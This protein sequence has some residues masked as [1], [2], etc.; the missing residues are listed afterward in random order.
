M[1]MEPSG[2]T[3]RKPYFL[4]L[5]LLMSI[6]LSCTPGPT[7]STTPEPDATSP[8]PTKQGTAPA[9]KES[10]NSSTGDSQSKRAKLVEAP[11]PLKPRGKPQVGKRTEPASNASPKTIAKT[12]ALAESF[13]RAVVQGDATTVE[14]LFVS[15]DEFKRLVQPSF[16][17]ILGSVQKQNIEL[18]KRLIQLLKGKTVSDWEWRPGHETTTTPGGTFVGAVPFLSNGILSLTI[19]GSYLEISLKQLVYLADKWRILEIEAR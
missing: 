19:D 2:H 12:R 3:M 1:T 7:S 5:L 9:T 13:W 15:E 4:T 8:Q 18:A 11:T 14:G 10:P 6:G 17:A 16:H